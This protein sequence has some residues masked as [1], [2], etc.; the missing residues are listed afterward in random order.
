MF[1]VFVILVH[2]QVIGKLDMKFISLLILVIQNSSLVLLLRYSRTVSG[3]PYITSTA[4]FL[5]EVVKIGCS[6]SLLH[7]ELDYNSKKTAKC[8]HEIFI[9]FRETLW[10]AVPAFLYTIQNNL[11]YIALSKLDAAT[12]QVSSLQCVTMVISGVHVGHI[13]VEVIN[14]SII[15]CDHVK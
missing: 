12:Y 1:F 5:T 14:H 4:V 9:R 15:L 3:E 7:Y 2:D 11:L 13:S 8:I 10:V 6:I